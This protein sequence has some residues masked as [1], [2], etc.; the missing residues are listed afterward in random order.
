MLKLLSK[1]KC[2]LGFHDSMYVMYV[3]SEEEVC[4]RCGKIIAGKIK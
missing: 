1:I 2:L 4:A 3:E